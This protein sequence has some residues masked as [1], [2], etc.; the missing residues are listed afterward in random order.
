VSSASDPRTPR[1]DNRRAIILTSYR[2]GATRGQNLG[3]PGYSY[4]LVARLF[5]PLLTRWGEVI[6]VA[7]D[8][9]A[10]EKAVQAARQRGL[11]PIHVGVLPCQDMVFAVS[12]PNVIVPAWEFPDVPDEAFEG[13]PQNNWV[14]TANRCDLVIVG[15]QFTVDSFRRAGI[16]TPI[17]VVAVPTSPE[18][19]NLPRWTAESRT[20]IDCPAYVFPNPDVPV[21]ELWDA[22]D[23]VGQAAR[24][25][26]QAGKPDLHGWRRRW[27]GRLEMILP[28][29]ITQAAHGLAE[30]WRAD[31][32]QSYLRRC[33]RESLELSGVVYTCIFNPHDGRKNYQDLLTGFTSALHDCPDATLILKLV[34]A[35]RLMID[36]VFDFYRGVGLMHRCKIVVISDYLSDEQMLALARASTY[37]LTTTRAEG[38]CLPLMNYLAA[39]RPGISPCHTAISDYFGEDIGLTLPWHAEPAIWPQDNR[40]RLKT[41]WARLDWPILVQRLRESHSLALHNRSA[42]DTRAVSAQRRMHQRAG[43][44]SVWAQLRGALEHLEEIRKRRVRAS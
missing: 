27:L 41:T 7:R 8:G 22:P 31:K 21:Q 15:G 36:R 44:E 30:R 29:L 13:N 32:W 1:G 19:F 17:R 9:E 14:A 24:P 40:A 20:R 4:D 28:P 10:V 34:T 35:E 26:A 18:Y 16:H 2:T 6:P 37:Y 3:V 39:G 12:A 38:N 23:D 5:T 42:Y 11:D 33:R 25:D 43:I